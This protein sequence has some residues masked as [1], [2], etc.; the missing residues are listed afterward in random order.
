MLETQIAQKTPLSSVPL[1][2]LPN[3]P[4]PN[5]REYCS[6]VIMKEDEED[7]TDV[8]EI[9]KEEGREITMAGS[10]KSNYGGKTPTFVENDSI[11][12]PTIF[13]HKLPDLGSFSIPWV[14]VRVEIERGPCDLGASVSIMSYSLFHKLHRGPLLATPFSL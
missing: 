1:D 4:E 5:P 10:K 11:Q 6:C 9:P 12:I 14:V 8:E 13:S 7:L 3:K 2:R